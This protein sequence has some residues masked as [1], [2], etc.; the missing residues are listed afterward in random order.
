MLNQGVSPSLLVKA[1]ATPDLILVMFPWLFTRSITRDPHGWGH[2]HGRV[3]P[4][5]WMFLLVKVIRGHRGHRG[6][7]PEG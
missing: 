3:S 4:T 7:K 5:V 1:R 6:D 2:A